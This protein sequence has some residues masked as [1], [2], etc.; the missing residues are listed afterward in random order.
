MSQQATVN[1]VDDEEMSSQGSVNAP[2]APQ[3]STTLEQMKVQAQAPTELLGIPTTTSLMGTQISRVAGPSGDSVRTVPVES[4]KVLVAPTMVV[5]A[6]SHVETKQAF[7]EVSSAL[8][9]VSLQHD[10]VHT[11]MEQ[12][13]RGMEQ[14]RMERAG[15][16]ETTAQVKE[17][18]QRTMS[19]S[20]LLEAQLGQAET[21]Q[22]EMRSVGEEAKATSDCALEQAA[23]LHEEQE[24]T[25]Q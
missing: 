9:S 4:T 8:H 25:S 23:C 12:L 2:V 17:T 6:P 21:E 14:M 13:S 11:E 16:L 20:S 7:V 24:Q 22:A 3:C 10:A 15:E 19:A 1:V 5:D 18:L